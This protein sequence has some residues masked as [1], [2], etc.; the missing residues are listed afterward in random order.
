M[1]CNRRHADH[2]K[3]ARLGVV[4]IK[5]RC[6]GWLGMRQASIPSF[7][8]VPFSVPQQQQQA[9]RMQLLHRILVCA[10][11][12]EPPVLP[13]PPQ[14]GA[15]DQGSA[16]NCTARR[17]SCV[18]DGAQSLALR[19]R[20]LLLP[21]SSPQLRRSRVRRF[22]SQ[23]LHAC[24]RCV[25]RTER[26]EEGIDCLLVGEK[27]ENGGRVAQTAEQ[28]AGGGPPCGRRPPAPHSLHGGRWYVK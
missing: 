9:P 27:V 2:Q 26:R 1:G 5:T 21:S 19:R 8:Y 7:L 23:R 18:S 3:P 20:A 28:R 12:R 13:P 10:R 6:R 15:G 14:T 17:A 25:Y 4:I 11:G 22:G 16:V 24:V